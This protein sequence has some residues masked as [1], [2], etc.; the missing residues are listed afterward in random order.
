MI[1]RELLAGSILIFIDCVSF[2]QKDNNCFVWSHP[3]DTDF[4]DDPPGRSPHLF[5][6]LVASTIHKGVLG[7]QSFSQHIKAQDYGVFINSLLP[8]ILGN[9]PGKRVVIFQDNAS[10]FNCNAV[11]IYIGE[12]IQVWYN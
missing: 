5:D 2:H 9:F 4:L 1:A 3:D 6:T 10:V 7:F 8:V 11:D 12:R